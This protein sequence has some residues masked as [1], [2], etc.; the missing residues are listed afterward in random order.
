MGLFGCLSTVAAAAPCVCDTVGV[1]C[2]A[3]TAYSA[4]QALCL[5]NIFI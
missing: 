3:A 2:A 1:S 5:V 4:E